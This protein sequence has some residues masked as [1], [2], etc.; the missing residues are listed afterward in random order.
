M[1]AAERM[2][3][4]RLAN[5]ERNR[6]LARDQRGKHREKYRAKWRRQ[7]AANAAKRAAQ[8]QGRRDAD[9]GRYNAIVRARRNAA[10]E[11]NRAA[12]GN[13]RSRVIGGKVTAK[14]IL[15]QLHKQVG[16]CFYCQ[17]KISVRYEV[18]HF[19]SL[20]NG[21]PHDPTNIVLACP[22]CNRK[23]NKLNGD[24]FLAKIGRA[25]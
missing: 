20:V 10:P 8:A 25:A 7:Y 14:D 9:R 19:I 16:L 23:K 21:G 3:R 6:Q 11:K 1:T 2:K 4:W 17:A 5:P 24:Q 18:D 15:E 13:R 22:P 12:C